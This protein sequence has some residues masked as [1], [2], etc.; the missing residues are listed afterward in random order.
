M[1]LRRR[2]MEAMPTIRTL[3]DILILT[4]TPD[5]R[6]IGARASDSTGVPASTGADF[7]EAGTTAVAVLPAAASAVEWQAGLVAAGLWVVTLGVAVAVN[8]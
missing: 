7:T 8:E 6:I 2:L 5:T 4:I 1:P 3:M